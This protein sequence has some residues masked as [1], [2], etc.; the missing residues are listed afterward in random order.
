[1][2]TII[3]ATLFLGCSSNKETAEDDATPPTSPTVDLSCEDDTECDA[4]QICEDSDCIA[5]DRSN[6]FSEAIAFSPD[7]GEM[8]GHIN[9]DG[10]LD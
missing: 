1:M 4:H 10:D 8:S 6:D 5:G 9:V 3:V 2:R 7:D